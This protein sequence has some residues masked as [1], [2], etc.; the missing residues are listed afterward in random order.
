MAFPS[1]LIINADD[2]GANT[3]KNLAIAKCFKLGIINSASVIPNLEGFTEAIQ[4]SKENGFQNKI[5]IHVN[6]TEGK[7][8]TDLS[9]IKLVDTEGFFIKKRVKKKYI[10]LSS[11]GKK[12]IKSEIEAQLNLIYKNNI[13]PTHINSHH[14]VHTLPWLIFPFLDVAKKFNV[15]LRIAQTWNNNNNNMLIPIYRSLLNWIYKRNKLNFTSRFETLES[16]S[17][18]DKKIKSSHILTEIMVHP[19]LNINK[20]IYDSF[21]GNLLEP[22]INAL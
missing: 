22:L 3:T 2:F 1:H 19:D 15:R 16:Y 11:E 14:H 8:L 20:D 21:D 13:I 5:G 4:M 9:K 18:T 6:L 17:R 12:L 10:Y 7:A